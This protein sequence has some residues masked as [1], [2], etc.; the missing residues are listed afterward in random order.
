MAEPPTRLLAHPRLARIAIANRG[1]GGSAIA[2]V[3]GA[4]R[5]AE[6]GL[7]GRL[8]WVGGS[9]VVATLSRGSP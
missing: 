2:P 5:Y 4:G 9:G 3:G 8:G 6:C 1:S 7:V